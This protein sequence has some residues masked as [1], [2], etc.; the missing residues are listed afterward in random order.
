MKMKQT[1][2]TFFISLM[3]FSLFAQGEYRV[4]VVGLDTS[5]SIAFT[6]EL[7]G[8]DK[9][10]QYI[11]FRVVAAYPYGSKTIESSYSRIPGYINQMKEMGVEIVASIE[12]LLEKSDYILLETNDGTVHLE[13][14]LEVFKHCKG[15]PFFIDKP[16]AATLAEAIAIFQLAKEYNVPIFSSSGVRFTPESQAIRRGEEGEV[17]GATTYS[18]ALR[19]I[20]HPDFGW[21]GIHGVEELFTVMGTGCVAVNRMSAEGTDVVTGL[22]SDGRVGTFRGT[23]T[24]KHLYG[25]IVF[26]ENG[27]TPSGGFQGY[28]MLLDEIV[29]FFRTGEPPVSEMETLEI[30]TFMEASNVSKRNNGEIILMEDVYRWAMYDAQQLIKNLE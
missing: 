27:V 24:G 10:E 23:R 30:F 9:K 1:G 5:H 4:G 16:I 6:K 8:E 3:C 19:E 7:N 17:L 14:A 26:T 2:L 15:K 18:P 28:G 21:Y 29:K 20:T 11:G 13:Q 22:W 25:G 12:E